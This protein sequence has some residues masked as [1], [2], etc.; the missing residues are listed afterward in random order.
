MQIYQVD[1]GGSAS[2]GLSLLSLLK[3]E[4][5]LIFLSAAD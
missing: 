5:Y 2:G 3:A 4:K 1:L